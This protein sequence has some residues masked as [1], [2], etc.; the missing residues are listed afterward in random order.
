[1]KS[2]IILV[3]ILLI[4]TLSFAEELILV[5]EDKDEA[6]YYEPNT[7]RRTGQFAMVWVVTLKHG[8]KHSEY[9]TEFDCNRATYRQLAHRVFAEGQIVSGDAIYREWFD[10]PNTSQVLGLVF[11]KVCPEPPR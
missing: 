5:R 3:C 2:F 6:S 11:K 10:V 7:I 9:L 8:E 4:S 1:V